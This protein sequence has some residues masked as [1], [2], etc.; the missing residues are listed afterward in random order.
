MNKLYG[1][2]EGLEIGIQR[3]GYDMMVEK[4]SGTSNFPHLLTILLSS[5]VIKL[6]VL[7]YAWVLFNIYSP[8]SEF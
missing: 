4:S 3:R 2:N 5:M 8:L 7:S 6:C 1:A